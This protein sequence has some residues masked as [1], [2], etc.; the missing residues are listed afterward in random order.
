[1]SLLAVAL[2]GLALS[3]VAVAVWLSRGA[4]TRAGGVAGFAAL[5]FGAGTVAIGASVT[6]AP[7]P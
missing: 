4:L 2:I 3:L 7:V 6:T 5:G 1:M